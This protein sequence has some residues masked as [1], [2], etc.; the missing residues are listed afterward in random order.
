MRPYSTD[1]RERVVRAC[2]AG[3]GTQAEV[4]ERFGVSRRFVQTLVRRWREDGTLEPR[5]HGG[6]QPAK[7]SPEQEQQI[8]QVLQERP[9]AT[10][11]EIRDACGVEGSLS[12]VERALKRM[13]VTRKKKV[14][15]YAEQLEDEVDVERQQWL[16]TVADEDPRRFVFLDEANAKANMTRLYGRAPR[17]KRVLGYVPDRRYESLT[18]LSALDYD[19]TTHCV[20]YDGGT[21]AGVMRTFVEQCLG[22]TLGPGDVVA[23][24]NLS[25]H[26][27]DAVVAAIEATGAEVWFLPRYSPDMNPLEKMWSKVKG[28]LRDAAART[29]DALV[30]AI[31]RALDAVTPDDARHWFE[32]CMHAQT[33][34]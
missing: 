29:K 27:D 23:M 8:R 19:G 12:C 11:A 26:K 32:H 14:L 10:L 20:V 18:M 22:P 21:D 31:G 16:A 25:A 15:R 3:E 7:V 34:S 30:D 9:D 4:A 5:P 1:L 13:G 28:L 2:E 33:Q 24:D 17:G 6:G